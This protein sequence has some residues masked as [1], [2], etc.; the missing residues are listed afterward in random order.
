MIRFR[1]YRTLKALI[2]TGT[3][4]VTIVLGWYG[5]GRVQNLRSPLSV[6][7]LNKGTAS[8][9]MDYTGGLRIASFNIAHG[10]GGTYGEKNWKHQTR[11]E[12]LAH[13]DRIVAQIREQAPDAIVL[14]EVDFSSAWS[15]A[16]DQAQYIADKSGYRYLL[17]QKN[18]DV[19]FP[20]YR[21]CF[22]N[23]LLSKFPI[24]DATSIMFKPYSEVERLAVG[25]HDA[26]FCNLRL[27]S[28]R[29][30]GIFGIHMEYRSEDVRV[31]CAKVLAEKSAR[32][33][34]PLIALG[35][36][37]SSPPP[38]PKSDVSATGENA[39]SY[40][41]NSAGFISYLKVADKTTCTFPSERPD[42]L[43]DWIMGKNIAGFNNG[44]IVHANLSDHFMIV[45]DVA[46]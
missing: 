11:E 29:T 8:D 44:S 2:L 16:V 7:E 33:G 36:F 9:E 35:D 19:H 34:Y 20:F 38:L 24:E 32:I 17:K 21:F 10:R 30:V 13:L 27:A 4:L 5:V 37:N 23:A 18:M 42:R 43:I 12:L 3:V 25:N 6:H 41:F 15:L 39:I 31:Q 14:N 22:G 40:L 45:A 26:F 28:N 1:R 46:F